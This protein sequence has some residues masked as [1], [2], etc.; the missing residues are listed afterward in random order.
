MADFT[1]LVLGAVYDPDGST[2][3]VVQIDGSQVFAGSIA[4][5]APLLEPEMPLV[6]LC[7]WTTGSELAGN[8]SVQIS[9]ESGQAIF[10]MLAQEITANVAGNIVT[11][12]NEL[13]YPDPY[14]NSHAVQ[15]VTVNGIAVPTPVNTGKPETPGDIRGWHYQFYGGAPLACNYFCGPFTA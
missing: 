5:G 8:V 14:I 6:E 12:N 1:Y 3:M 2:N 13:E 7:R 4:S 9:V 10:S 15:D 11:Y